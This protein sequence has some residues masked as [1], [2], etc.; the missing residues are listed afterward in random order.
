MGGVQGA[1]ANSES[2]ERTG[3]GLGTLYDAKGY[4]IQNLI[5][6][7]QLGTCD[8]PKAGANGS[9]ANYI[10]H[11]RSWEGQGEQLV[12]RRGPHVRFWHIAD[13]DA[14]DEHVRFWG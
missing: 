13:I 12:G 4:S 9:V 14:D 6:C 3:Y 11:E 5:N 2:C 1:E 8:N 10:Q 7:N